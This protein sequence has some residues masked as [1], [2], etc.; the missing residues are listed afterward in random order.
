MSVGVGGSGCI[1]SMHVEVRRQ[2]HACGHCF[3][4]AMCIPGFELGS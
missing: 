4:P 3:S 1:S 2:K